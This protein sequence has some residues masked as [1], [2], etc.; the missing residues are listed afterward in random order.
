MSFQIKVG[1]VNQIVTRAAHWLSDFIDK[2]P[3]F[4]GAFVVTTEDMSS[5]PSGMAGQ[6]TSLHLWNILLKM[7]K[8]EVLEPLELLELCFFLQDSFSL[9]GASVNALA[10]ELISVIKT[11]DGVQLT[12]KK[13]PVEGAIRSPFWFGD[14][15]EGTK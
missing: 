14:E 15:P 7:E 8:G 9:N 11:K 12:D 5:R 1:R 13:S 2:E 4:F 3:R 10:D 6:A